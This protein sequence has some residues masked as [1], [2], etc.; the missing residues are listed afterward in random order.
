M[1]QKTNTVAIDFALHYC[2]CSPWKDTDLS[3]IY[4]LQIQAKSTVDN[5]GDQTNA[6][7]NQQVHTKGL[8]RRHH[9]STRLSN[10]YELCLIF[11]T[12]EQ[13]C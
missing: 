12:P 1:K 8:M 5:A 7:F 2:T 4:N 3:L 11:D 13:R 9:L 10:N 6:N